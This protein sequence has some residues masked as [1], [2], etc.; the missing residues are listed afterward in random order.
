MLH[1]DHEQK[2]GLWL[3]YI[4]NELQA[5]DPRDKIFG[6]PGVMHTR[7][8][9][10]YKNSARD[11][12]CEFLC[13]WESEIGNLSILNFAGLNFRLDD[14]PE[15]QLPSWVPEWQDIAQ[16]RR[17]G[18]PHQLLGFGA[19]Y[20]A[21]LGF[22]KTPVRYSSPWSAL[23]VSG[24]ICDEVIELIPEWSSDYV[25]TSLL[26]WIEEFMQKGAII[27]TGTGS[28][29]FQVIF[30][31]VFK[32]ILVHPNVRIDI[33]PSEA[34]LLVTKF[35]F[36]LLSKEFR[37]IGP[38]ATLQKHLPRLGLHS[39]A[40]FGKYYK[41]NIFPNAETIPTLPDWHDAK[42]ALWNQETG[43]A[44]KLL[45]VRTEVTALKYRR[46]FVTRLGYLGSL[47]PFRRKTW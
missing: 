40:E 2:I 21:S 5:T 36:V 7:L 1:R 19:A 35:L 24:A 10:D 14:R 39:G 41:Q 8:I 44:D 20:W 13:A 26:N 43:K 9:P 15:L 12:Y 33:K 30:R 16:T 25:A 38:D 46:M 6:L 23:F 3:V 28:P 32:D 18:R 11:V 45:P 31:T 4:C 22:P 27:E 29:I 34:H 47:Y 17:Q 37:T 42:T